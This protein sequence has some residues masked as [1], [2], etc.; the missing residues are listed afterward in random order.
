[1]IRKYLRSYGFASPPFDEFALGAIYLLPALTF[2]GLTI[3]I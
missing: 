1:M 3:T 2:I